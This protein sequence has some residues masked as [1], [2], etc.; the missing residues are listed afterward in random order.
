MPAGCR[1]V[2]DGGVVAC[3]LWAPKLGKVLVNDE[4]TLAADTMCET[5]AQAHAP[6]PG[7]GWCSSFPCMGE[8]CSHHF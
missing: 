4:S 7:S 1:Q 5:F 3:R 6:L 2:R 8:A